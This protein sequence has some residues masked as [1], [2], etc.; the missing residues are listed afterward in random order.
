MQI[1][2]LIDKIEE[3]ESI[4]EI[5]NSVI[6]NFEEY[7]NIKSGFKSFINNQERYSIGKFRQEIINILNVINNFSEEEFEALNLAIEDLGP[8]DFEETVEAI[9]RDDY[10]YFPD[11]ESDRD[12]GETYVNYIGSIEDAVGEENLAD[13]INIRELAQEYY[14]DSDDNEFDLED[15]VDFARE[16]IIEHPKD[17]LDFFDYDAFGKDLRLVDG[18]FIGSTGAIWIQ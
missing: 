6:N 4:E 5:T 12:L 10:I 1:T 2:N 3:T 18:Y 15:Y 9:N 16:E 17:F 14:D 7:P 8:W 13:Y 11:V